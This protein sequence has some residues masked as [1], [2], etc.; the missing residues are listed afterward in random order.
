MF[1][2]FLFFVYEHIEPMEG[3]KILAAKDDV[4]FVY[5]TF[6]TNFQL[7]YK[8]KIKIKLNFKMD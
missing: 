4:G 7:I 8:K 2:S 6:A 3:K 5:P 1:T